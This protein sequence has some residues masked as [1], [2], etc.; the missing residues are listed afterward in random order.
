MVW[1]VETKEYIEN[2]LNVGLIYI[3]REWTIFNI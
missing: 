3:D 1:V 2:C